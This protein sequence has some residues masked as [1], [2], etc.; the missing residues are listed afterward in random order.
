MVTMGAFNGSFNLM[1]LKIRGN[2]L[3]RLPDLS[4]LPKLLH[5]DLSENSMDCILQD[6]LSNLTSVSELNVAKNYI[7]NISIPIYIKIRYLNL[8]GNLLT[9]LN[10]IGNPLIL[11]VDGTLSLIKVEYFLKFQFMELS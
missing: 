10:E 3:T 4:H 5:L 2:Y 9:T 7:T 6:D 1:V 8:Q 11:N